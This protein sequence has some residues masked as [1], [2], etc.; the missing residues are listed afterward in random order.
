M[1]VV[2]SYM[3]FRFGFLR[4]QIDDFMKGFDFIV[5]FKNILNDGDEGY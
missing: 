2:F 5:F 4:N 3:L 1:C